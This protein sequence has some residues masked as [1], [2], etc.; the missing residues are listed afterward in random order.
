M[1]EGTLPTVVEEEREMAATNG[2]HASLM[3]PLGVVE[4]E[5]LL[6]LDHHGAATLRRLNQQVEAPAYLVMMAVG[7][8][9]RSGLVRAVQRDLEVVVKLRKPLARLTAEDI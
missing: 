7:A 5:V 2:E 9:T 1:D 4:G 6:Y 3:T 8:L